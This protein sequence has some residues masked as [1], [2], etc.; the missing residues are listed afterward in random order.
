MSDDPLFQPAQ[1]G[2]ISVKNRIVMAPLTRSRAS[3]HEVPSDLA[4][5]YYRQRAGAGLIVSEG[6][7]IRQD[8]QGYVSTPGIYSPAQL[9]GWKKVTAAVHEAGG[10]IVAQIWHVGRISH[11]DLIGGARP[12]APSAIRANSKTFLPNGNFDPV[13]EPRALTIEE[14]KKVVEDF[15]N[16]A[17]N[18]VSAGFDGVEIHGANG[19]LIDQF[20]KDGANKRTDEYGGP[21]ENRVRFMTEVV[22]ASVAAIGAGRVG[23]RLSPVTPSNDISEFEPAALVRSG[24]LGTVQAQDCL[25][26]HDRGRHAGTARHR[27]GL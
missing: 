3:A 6:T 15:G 10:K 22:D 14:I 19:Y 24:G 27:P 17:K 1:V 4:P 23:I 20:L 16:A 21:I 9:E 12:V 7:Q 5:T 18:A 25:H 2:D 11:P 13:G 8:G 26:P